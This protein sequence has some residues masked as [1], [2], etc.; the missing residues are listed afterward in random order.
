MRKLPSGSQ[1]LSQLLEVSTLVVALPESTPEP[2]SIRDSGGARGCGRD[3]AMRAGF[4]RSQATLPLSPR[5]YR[6]YKQPRGAGHSCC[7]ALPEAESAGRRAANLTDSPAPSLI[8]APASPVSS[9]VLGALRGVGM[10][11]NVAAETSVA[12]A[13]A[14]DVSYF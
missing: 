6:R 2:S 7:R 11:E 9:A 5:R 14:D 12:Q 3:M 10:G 13:E 1:L 8:V 4:T